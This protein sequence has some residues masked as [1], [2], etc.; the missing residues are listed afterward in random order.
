MNQGAP[1]ANGMT[2]KIYEYLL[3]KIQSCEYR[4]GEEINEKTLME[5]S[6]F[7]RTPLREALHALQRDGL[8]EIFPR[9][10]M[11]I[12]PITARGIN[13]IYQ[14]RLL[15]EP[16]IVERYAP[17]YSRLTLMDFADRFDRMSVE[18]LQDH[19]ALDYDF[20]AFLM[21]ITQN[22]RI[23]SLHREIMIHTQRLSRHAV[24]PGAAQ[25]DHDKPEHLAIINA[26]LGGDPPRAR[27]AL[28]AHINQ[29]LVTALRALQSISAGD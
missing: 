13:E 26:L 25:L 10:G 17:F 1:A 8:V 27:Q 24:K 5:D 7:G 6:G 15:I 3:E 9:K 21:G 19:Y 12:S 20:H 16:E 29:S 4:P 23:I 2:G 28:I 11:R 22:Q 18:N 14:L